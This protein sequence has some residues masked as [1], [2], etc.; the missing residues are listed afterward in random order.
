MISEAN[1]D[2]YNESEQAMGLFTMV[3]VA[4]RFQPPCLAS[5]SMCRKSNSMTRGRLLRFVP[6]AQRSR[7]SH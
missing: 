1:V 7:G 6:E 5:R 3:E 2:C 4:S